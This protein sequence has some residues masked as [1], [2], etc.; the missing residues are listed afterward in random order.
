M[1]DMFAFD[2]AVYKMRQYFREAKG[3]IEVPTQ[4]RRSILAACED[5]KTIS[6]YQ[7]NGVNWPLPQTG[8]MWL[9]Y[10]LLKNPTVKGVGVEHYL[11]D[12]RESPKWAPEGFI[13][14]NMKSHLEANLHIYRHEKERLNW[15]RLNS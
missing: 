15:G 4:S 12:D 2:A 5:P 13:W 3:F 7:F 11:Y 1:K 10:E 6:Q 14:D 8:Q 9:E